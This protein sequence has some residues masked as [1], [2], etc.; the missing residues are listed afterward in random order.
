MDGFGQKK[1]AMF[2]CSINILKLVLVIRES[3]VEKWVFVKNENIV[4]I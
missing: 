1:V 3:I 2:A 4:E